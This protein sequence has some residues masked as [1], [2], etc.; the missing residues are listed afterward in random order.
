[1]NCRKGRAA[2][3]RGERIANLPVQQ[4]TNFHLVINLRTAREMGLTI[5]QPIMLTADE[6][7]E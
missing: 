4:P 2:I 3:G 1:V 5:P 7:I 6:V